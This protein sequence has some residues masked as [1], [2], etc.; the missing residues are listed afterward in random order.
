[1]DVESILNLRSL[2]YT[3][4]KIAA[5]LGISRATVYRRLE[6]VGISPDD[7]SH[8]S[9][10]ELDQLIRTIKQDH[11]N[12]GEVLILGHLHRMGIRVTRQALR[13]SI[14]RTDHVNVIARRR[15]V[16]RRR[17]YYVPHPNYMWHI[18]GHHKLIQWR[19]VIHGAIDGFSCAIVYLKCSDNNRAPTVLR[20]FQ[21]GVSQFGLPEHVRSDHGGENVDVY[22]IM[23]AKM[24]M[25]RDT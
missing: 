7:N 2:H 15:T 3:W 11:P 5:I 24:W 18:D 8:L 12:D 4:T 16:I 6:E 19:F 14:H 22:L 23:E 21:D 20:L 9:D 13:D 10:Q 17:I 1:M 25:Y